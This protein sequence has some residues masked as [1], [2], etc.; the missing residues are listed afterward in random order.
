M[1]ICILIGTFRSEVACRVMIEKAT[2]IKKAKIY[3][4][5]LLDKL[6]E[7]KLI[8]EELEVT[9]DEDLDDEV[10][11]E[12]FQI[13]TDKVKESGKVFGTFIGIL[14]EEDTRRAE[15]LANKLIEAYNKCI[16]V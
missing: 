9:G 13:I 6:L 1:N 10:S 3:L 2:L 4:K 7:E 15:Q 11:D 12:L 14:K 5:L 8:E 16:D